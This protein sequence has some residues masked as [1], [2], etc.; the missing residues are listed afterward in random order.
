[1]MQKVKVKTMAESLKILARESVGKK[2]ARKLRYDGFI[3]GVLY[4]GGKQPKSI[5]VAL[6]DLR[7]Y[8]FSQSF[9]STVFETDVDGAKEDI[10]AKDI[11]FHPVTDVPISVDFMRV[12]KDAKIKVSIALEFINSEKSPG[13]KKGGV[14]NVVVHQIE[15]S[16]EVGN[17]PEKFEVD[18]SGKE[19][20]TS[21]TV[22]DVVFPNGV[23]PV[24][25]SN[26]VIATIVSPRTGVSTDENNVETTE[27][28][29]AAG[30]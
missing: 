12:S 16:C 8:C 4:G 7:Q 23:T 6:K 15:C 3:P 30:A 22:G 9:F 26:V 19:I 14:L 28:E 21:F 1:M 18:L 5:S 25:S 13:V 27:G 11:S 24:S 2:E 20:G 29:Q 17:I 10:I